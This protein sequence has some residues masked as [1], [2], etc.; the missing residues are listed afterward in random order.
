MSSLRKML[1]D[2]VTCEDEY[3]EL[4]NNKGIIKR[5]WW[6]DKEGAFMEQTFKEVDLKPLRTVDAELN[7]LKHLT[8]GDTRE[9]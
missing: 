7:M 1:T 3:K 6:S 2:G 8:I 5:F 4:I 9:L